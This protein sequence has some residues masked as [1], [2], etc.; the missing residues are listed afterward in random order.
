VP[1]EARRVQA[2]H[3]RK[4]FDFFDSIQC[5]RCSFFGGEPDIAVPLAFRVVVKC[6]F[7]TLDL[8]KLRKDPVQVFVGQALVDVANPNIALLLGVVWQVL[9]TCQVLQIRLFGLVCRVLT[10]SFFKS[11]VE[12]Q[13]AAHFARV[14]QFEVLHLFDCNL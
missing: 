13:E 3:K 5:V 9:T 4:V 2:A 14:R 12:G 1:H 8:S 6:N 7:G 10:V 11:L